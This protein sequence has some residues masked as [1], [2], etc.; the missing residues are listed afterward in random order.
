MLLHREVQVMNPTV[1]VVGPDGLNM[2]TLNLTKEEFVQ[3]KWI[4]AAQRG[5]VPPDMAIGGVA[6]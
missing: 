4:A 3:F 5:I 6:A 1:S 2:A